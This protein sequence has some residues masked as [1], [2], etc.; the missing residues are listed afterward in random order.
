MSFLKNTSP[1]IIFV[2]P[3]CIG[4]DFKQLIIFVLTNFPH[5]VFNTWCGY[6]AESHDHLMTTLGDVDLANTW[7]LIFWLGYY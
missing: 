7:V 1:L 3:L 2:G 4:K 6:A 5:M